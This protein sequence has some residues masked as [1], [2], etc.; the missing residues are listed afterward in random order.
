MDNQQIL[1]K[2][3]QGLISFANA[4]RQQFPIRSSSPDQKIINKNNHRSSIEDAAQV[5]YQ[6]LKQLQK[7]RTIQKQELLN[8]RNQLYTLKGSLEESSVY[9]SI[10]KQAKIDQLLKQLRELSTL[11]EQMRPD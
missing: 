10:E 4:F 5:C 3:D 8:F 9:S 7:N 11:A 6:T 1:I 2:L